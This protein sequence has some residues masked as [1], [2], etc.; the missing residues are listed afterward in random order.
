MH[1]TDAK[2]AK[3]SDAHEWGPPQPRF[4]GVKMSGIKYH[5]PVI[6]VVMF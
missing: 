1:K 6:N 5:Y 4:K 3:Q 2:R